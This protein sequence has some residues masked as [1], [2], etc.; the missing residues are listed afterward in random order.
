[1]AHI[2][3]IKAW[4]WISKILS[5][6]FFIY[7][8][9]NIKQVQMAVEGAVL[10]T[11][12]QRKHVDSGVGAI[13]LQPGDPFLPPTLGSSCPKVTGQA[14]WPPFLWDSLYSWVMVKIKRGCVGNT[15]YWHALGTQP[16]VVTIINYCF[17]IK[18]WRMDGMKTGDSWK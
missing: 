17:G 15:T 3:N 14:N 2:W 16:S 11:C 4:I 5:I 13:R 12:L 1:M 7:Q 8:Q 9:I 10:L 18:G 6:L